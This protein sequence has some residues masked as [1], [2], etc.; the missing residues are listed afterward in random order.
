M[1]AGER[2]LD[3]RTATRERAALTSTTESRRRW[4]RHDAQLPMMG[5]TKEK[6]QQGLSCY[7][8]VKVEVEVEVEVRVS[9]CLWLVGAL[10]R[11]RAETCIKSECVREEMFMIESHPSRRC[12]VPTSQSVSQ[13]L[14][15]ARWCYEMV[16]CDALR[17]DAI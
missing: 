10:Y 11:E 1:S 14:S 6:Q 3:C 15:E 9:L 7:G 17:C 12:G 13:L 8:E 2:K 16:R 5:A 4:P